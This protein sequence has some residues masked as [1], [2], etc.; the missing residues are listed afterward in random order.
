MIDKK[1]I[2]YYFLPNS[3]IHCLQGDADT[4]KFLKNQNFDS[5]FMDTFDISEEYT[6]EEFCN[7]NYEFNKYGFRKSKLNCPSINNTPNEIW[8]FGDSFT[9][10]TG[11]PS[12]RTWPAILQE[13][14]NQKVINFG[15]GGA[16]PETIL[17]LLKSW[18]VHSKHK[19]VTV[20]IYGFFPGRFEVERDLNYEGILT[21]DF[22]EKLNE[23]PEKETQ[24]KHKIL[25]IDAFYTN[26]NNN[27]Y[28]LISSE[29]IKYHTLD[30]NV[31]NDWRYGDKISFGRDLLPKKLPRHEIFKSFHLNYH[32]FK[33]LMIVHPGV[34]HHKFI[35]K[36][37][38][39]HL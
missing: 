18:L 11:V 26:W 12:D 3:T 14:T 24:M 34:N 36:E 25:N 1:L 32:E 30:I 35:A 22:S 29:D 5:Y 13:Y 33:N 10:G 38:S 17:R 4:I 2:S 8:C 7:F 39:K 20:F 37:F 23:Y 15:V 31:L 21:S 16:G 28:E 9:M 19:P 6:I 27:I